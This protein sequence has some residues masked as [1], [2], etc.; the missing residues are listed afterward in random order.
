M[1]TSLRGDTPLRSD[2]STERLAFCGTPQVE[3]QALRTVDR[4]LSALVRGP[5]EPGSVQAESSVPG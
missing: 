1:T 5:A 2:K 4:E 3:G